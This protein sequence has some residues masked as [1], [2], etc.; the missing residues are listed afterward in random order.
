MILKEEQGEKQ[1]RELV[2]KN[3]NGK[4]LCIYFKPSISSY[5]VYGVNLLLRKICQKDKSWDSKK[6]SLDRIN[7]VLRLTRFLD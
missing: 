2:S 4:C 5:H 3:K 6:R 7:E 1:P